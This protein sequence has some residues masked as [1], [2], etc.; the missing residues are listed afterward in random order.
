MANATILF[1]SCHYFYCKLTYLSFCNFIVMCA[2]NYFVCNFERR[3][4][5]K[6]GF[7]NNGKVTCFVRL[8]MVVKNYYSGDIVV[9][10]N[11]ISL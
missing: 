2:I 5:Y 3:G 9:M 11:H 4:S 8:K 10:V 7:E 6:L 1:P